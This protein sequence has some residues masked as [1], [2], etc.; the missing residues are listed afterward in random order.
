M[1][2]LLFLSLVVL[3]LTGNLTAQIQSRI[4]E[5]PI[6]Y[7]AFSY[8]LPKTVFKVRVTIRTTHEEPGIYARYS[9]RLLG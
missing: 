2:K 8:H 4:V 9:E 1:K 6:P 7:E 5:G 3:G